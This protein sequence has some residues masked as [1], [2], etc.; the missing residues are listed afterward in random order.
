M[1]TDAGF[2][3]NTCERCKKPI[4]ANEEE[5]MVEGLRYHAY[6]HTCTQ[7]KKQL[8]SDYKQH[9]GKL[10]C[11]A[12][13]AKVIAPLCYVCRK[14]IY[15]R[16]I[17]AIGKQFHPGNTFFIFETNTLE[18]FV[19]TKCEQP[20]TNSTFHE[21]QGKPYCEAHFNELAGSKCYRCHK[22]AQGKVVAGPSG[23]KY[24]ADHF[25]CYGCD[26]NLAKDN[27]KFYEWDTKTM[28]SRCFDMIPSDIRKHLKK[29]ADIE[30]EL[31]K[32][33]AKK[34]K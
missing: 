32:A 12:D 21:H 24:C 17:T 33:A 10:Y 7:C 13:Y 1:Y 26:I 9:D 31:A 5:L 15:G 25:S 23:R 3:K 22:F 4:M 6:H 28:C 19:C 27:Q 11:P 34:K 2:N 30:I 18:H 16:V 14:P 29:Y 8:T 20:F